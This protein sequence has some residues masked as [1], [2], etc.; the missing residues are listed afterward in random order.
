[1]RKEKYRARDT[2]IETI[3]KRQFRDRYTKKDRIPEGGTEN[4][5]KEE[6]NIYE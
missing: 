6:R 5:M 1:M 3:E 4:N 2:K